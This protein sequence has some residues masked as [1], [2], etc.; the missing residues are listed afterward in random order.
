MVLPLARE[1]GVST[2]GRGMKELNIVI[3]V[4]TNPLPCYLVARQLI[5]SVHKT[6]N[7]HSYHLWL[8]HSRDNRTIS[9]AGTTRQAE[10]VRRELVESGALAA[11]DVSFIGLDDVTSP[12]SIRRE[13]IAQLS[14]RIEMHRDEP[15]QIHIDYTG[16][17]KSM[18]VSLAQVAQDLA[19]VAEFTF[20]YLD[21]R[22]SIMV[23]DALRPAL[24]TARFDVPSA[25]Y[26]V[27]LRGTIALSVS[28]LLSLH[29]I[30]RK[31]SKQYSFDGEDKEM[32]L[33]INSGRIDD[34][35]T[36]TRSSLRRFYGGG[37][38]Q[39][40][41]WE[42][43]AKNV[44]GYLEKPG[45]SPEDLTISHT[46]LYPLFSSPGL[47][48]LVRSTPDGA[49]AFRST[50]EGCS[51]KELEHA[52]E[53]LD[54]HW[55]ENYVYNISHELTVELGPHADVQEG[56]D[57]RSRFAANSS[58]HSDIDVAFMNGYQLTAISITTATNRHICKGKGFEVLLRASQMGGEES[59][60][61]LLTG[62]PLNDVTGLTEDLKTV[63]GSLSDHLLVLGRADWPRPILS[64][65]L[66]NHIQ[67]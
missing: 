56:V 50:F 9:Q 67:A 11:D 49:L 53:Y 52:L 31:S 25:G 59:R 57:C 17:T 46:S 48:L 51:A 54:G 4:G 26:S 21:A 15:V 8:V 19:D 23:F 6:P 36:L 44:Q 43:C 14:D 38:E 7:L 37:N 32:D 35:L 1:H 22:R 12:S 42:K 45:S 65:R 2:K 66:K 40:P 64:V 63:S 47:R 33:L 39:S 18:G 55:L 3:L 27:D 41:V 30:I 34:L 60:S 16:G 62:L 58:A 24:Y 61:V 5:A 13:V 10:N 20:S 28:K 29:D